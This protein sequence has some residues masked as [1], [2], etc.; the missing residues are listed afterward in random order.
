MESMEP[1]SIYVLPT[2]PGA[3]PRAI[4]VLSVDETPDGAPEGSVNLTGPLVT[5]LPDA[6]AWTIDGITPVE[7]GLGDAITEHAKALGV[8]W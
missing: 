1:V 5:W 3:P 8:K 2:I 4:L 6:G 7:Q